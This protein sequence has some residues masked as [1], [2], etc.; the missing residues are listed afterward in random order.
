MEM[1]YEGVPFSQEI[2]FVPQYDNKNFLQSLRS[3]DAVRDS[4][5]PEQYNIDAITRL[6]ATC[7]AIINPHAFIFCDDELNQFVIDQIVKTCP[8][9]IPAEHIPK[10]TVSDW[11]EDYLYGLKSLGLDLMITRTSKEN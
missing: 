7:I 3:E 8:K 5:N 6:I 2:S 10:I 11:K 1:W 9:Y 4:N